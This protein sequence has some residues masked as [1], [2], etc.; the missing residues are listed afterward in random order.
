MQKCLQSGGE[1]KKEERGKATTT[2]ADQSVTGSPAVLQQQHDHLQLGSDGPADDGFYANWRREREMWGL[3]G[4]TGTCNLTTTTTANAKSDLQS[5]VGKRKR[6]EE[7][8][9]TYIG[10]WWCWWLVEGCIVTR[11]AEPKTG[12][13]REWKGQR[14]WWLDGGNLMFW[15]TNSASIV[16]TLFRKDERNTSDFSKN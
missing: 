1:R 5:K 7:K 2:V 9:Q 13:S 3:T 16:F 6:R 8:S 15:V 14:E 11:V 4:S 10:D 12:R